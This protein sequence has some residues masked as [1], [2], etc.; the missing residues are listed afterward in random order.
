VSFM[1]MEQLTNLIFITVL[2]A[3]LHLLLMVFEA[4]N[5]TIIRVWGGRDEHGD[6][7]PV[8]TLT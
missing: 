6:P 1:P 7:D 4:N 2:I 8:D 3:L 5:G